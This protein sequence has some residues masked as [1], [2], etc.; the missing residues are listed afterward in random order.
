MPALALPPDTVRF[1]NDGPDWPTTPGLQAAE[2]AY[3][4]T[5][6]AGARD[7]AQWD[8]PDPDMID[9]AWRDRRRVRDEA[10]VIVPSAVLFGDGPWIGEQIIYRA[11]HEVAA[12][13]TRGR[14]QALELAKQL[15]WELEDAGVSDEQV[16]ESIIKPWVAKVE[17]WAASE[18]DPTHISPP[19]R[20]EE[21]ISEAQRRML[22]SPPKPKPQA[23]MPMLAKSLAV[24]RR[25]TDVERELLDWLWPGR[26]PLGKLTLLAGDPGLGK[27]FV[28][29]DIA[30]RVSRGLPWPDLPLLKQPPAGVLL[31]NAE[32]DLGDTIA[33][34]LDKMNADDRNIVAVEGVS[35]MGQRRHF[36]LESDLPRLAE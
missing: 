9:E 20:P 24:T 3:R 17:A 19:P 21:F 22:E 30:A 33:P 1:Y 25:L 36:S 4:H 11:G 23:A 15:W 18:I 16:I 14:C 28:T 31:F 34:R 13:R 32:D 27:S 2:R 12:S 5:F 8:M 35:V 6:V 29:L 10:Q 26:I 7:V